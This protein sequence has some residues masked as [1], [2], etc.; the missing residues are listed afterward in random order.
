MDQNQENKD[1]AS[2]NS[3]SPQ[4]NNAAGSNIANKI[5]NIISKGVSQQ[6]VWTKQL[7][8]GEI[9]HNNNDDS[10]I[11]VSQPES[12]EATHIPEKEEKPLPKWLQKFNDWHRHNMSDFIFLLWLAVVVGIF[13]GFGAHIFNRLI[14]ITSDIFLNHIKPDRINWWLLFVPVAGILI[15]GIYTRY[16]I[17][18]NLT[19]GVTRM[20][21]SLYKGMFLFRRNLIYSPIIGSAITL[22]FGGSAGSEGPIAI[23]GAAIGSNIGR[24]LQLKMPLVKVLVA[25]GAGAGIS[26]I[27]QSPVGGLLFTL[28]FLKMEIGTLSILAVMLACLVSYGVVFLCNGCHV[29][30]E[31]FPADNINPDQYGAA[32]L[33]GVLCGLYSAYYSWV[34]NRTDNIF[35]Q[36]KNPWWRNI[37]GGF[38]IGICLLL[39]P[40]LYGVGY[41]VMSEVIHSQ[42]DALSRGDVFLGM[43]IGIW[44]IMLVAFLILGIKCWA[45]GACNASGG[46]SS[47]FAPTLYAGAIAGFL[48]SYFS[49]EVLHTHLPIPAFVVIGMGAVMAGCIEAPMMTIFI[50]MNMSTD[51]AFLLAIILA[52]YASYI[53][54]RVFSHISGTDAK[55]VRHLQWFHEHENYEHTSDS[56]DGGD[57]TNPGNLTAPFKM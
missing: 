29:P 19:H 47:D 4:K 46:V 52:V 45:C 21:H 27:F 9:N 32:V 12:G 5:Q 31:F 26:G 15:A 55:L 20:M 51:V 24:W 25:C 39:F 56:G 23:S 18:T 41:P 33:L 34:I 35:I 57:A 8:Q 50:V 40:S 7:L 44:G 36:I 14:T 6:D 22:G 2:Q 1:T 28:E 13:S 38:S 48:F 3:D 53:T 17:H 43:N 16:V 37:I 10:G 11:K 49:N 54:V 30:T 42:F